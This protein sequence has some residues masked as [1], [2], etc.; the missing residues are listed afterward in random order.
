MHHAP[1]TYH[2]ITPP[3]ATAGQGGRP[4][5]NLFNL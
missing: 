4:P 2:I 5:L 3:A 1:I